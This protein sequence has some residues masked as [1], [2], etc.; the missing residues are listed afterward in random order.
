MGMYC[1]V[2]LLLI[3]VILVPHLLNLTATDVNDVLG[4]APQA[5]SML[6]DAVSLHHHQIAIESLLCGPS[7]LILNFAGKFQIRHRGMLFLL[8]IVFLDILL[9]LGL[10]RRG[11]RWTVRALQLRC[12]LIGFLLPHTG[13][14][15]RHYLLCKRGFSARVVRLFRHFILIFIVFF[16]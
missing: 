7:C 5:R 3:S 15:V 14:L 10:D 11:S 13:V 8:V 12:H 2:I 9:L 16:I 6:S 1:R 4:W